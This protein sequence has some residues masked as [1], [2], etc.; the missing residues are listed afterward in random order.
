LLIIVIVGSV[1][2]L[3][4]WTQTE[5]GKYLFDKFLLKIHFVGK[6]I[7]GSTLTNFTRTFGLLTT[8]GVPLLDSLNIVTDVIGNAVYKKAFQ[9]TFKGVERGLS[10][11]NQLDTVGVFPTLVPQMYRIGEET[12][13]VDRVSFKMADYFESETDNLVK[14]ITVV[15]EPI[16]LVVLGIGVAFLVISIILPIYKLTT[17]FS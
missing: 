7:S 5:N 9:D 13:K 1:V 11:S 10:F 14:N 6:I 3:R 12:G 8:A 15:I 4:Q 2:G 17:S 16:V